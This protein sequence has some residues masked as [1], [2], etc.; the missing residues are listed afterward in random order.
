MELIPTKIVFISAHF[1]VPIEQPITTEETVIEMIGHEIENMMTT[2]ES[3][4]NF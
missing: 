2:D 3:M 4:D 1:S